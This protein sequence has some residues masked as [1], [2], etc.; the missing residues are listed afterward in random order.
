MA[1]KYR[2]TNQSACP[3]AVK[4]SGKTPL[5]RNVIRTVLCIGLAD[6]YGNPALRV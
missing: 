6:E 4:E 1:I 3:P 5:F 2:F